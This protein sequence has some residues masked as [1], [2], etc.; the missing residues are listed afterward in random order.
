MPAYNAEATIADSITSLIAQTYRDWRLTVLDD[1]STDRTAEICSALARKDSRIKL[2]QLEHQGLCNALNHG[3]RI[4]ETPLVGRLD[5]DDLCQPTRLEKQIG[6]LTANPEVKVLGTWGRRI[7]NAGEALSNM[8]I[9]PISR[10]DYWRHRERKE[11]IFFIHSSVIADRPTLLSFGGYRTDDYPAE[12][13]WLWTRIA[14]HHLV[15]TLPEDL[16]GYRIT[17]GGISDANFFRQHIQMARL[18]YSL[19]KGR[20]IG[21]EDFQVICKKQPLRRIELYRDYLHRY[22]F[23]KGAGYFFNG[24]RATGSWYLVLSAVLDPRKVLRRALTRL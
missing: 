13:V 12:D 1:G 2:V 22:W 14:Q 15:L 11:P 6:F 9:G 20:W 19:E 23:R 4:A 3:L 7:N 16:V 24:R 5:S 18:R 10:E 21:T 8:R 17:G